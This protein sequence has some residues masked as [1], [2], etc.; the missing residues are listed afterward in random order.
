[1]PSAVFK[2]E[3]TV[4]PCPP[5]SCDLL[6]SLEVRWGVEATVKG[7]QDSGYNVAM[8]I[9]GLL[10]WFY[11]PSVYSVQNMNIVIVL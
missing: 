1:M 7:S 9:G 2:T 10:Y 8:D 11:K 3:T 6:M 5:L 4:R